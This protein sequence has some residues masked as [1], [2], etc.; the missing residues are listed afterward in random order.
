[1]SNR[2]RGA[3]AELIALVLIWGW[4]FWCL[5]Q[6]TVSGELAAE[7]FARSMGAVFA[8]TVL[9]SL[10]LNVAI[11]IVVDLAAGRS[12]RGPRDET[13]AWAGLRATRLAHG[14]L[15]SLLML[16]TALAFLFGGF[17]GQ[18]LEARATGL[19]ASVMDNG[20]ILFANGAL[21]AL[22]V[23]EIVHYGGLIWFLRRR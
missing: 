3:W 21:A 10:V 18:T 13:E 11:D 12:R 1:M 15:I 4:Y 20:L 5:V 7:G 19:L 9:V 23:A 2:E 17:T 16:L 14:V 22:I 6:V 8:V